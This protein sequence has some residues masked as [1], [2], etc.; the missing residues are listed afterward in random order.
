ME[1]SIEIEVRSTE[2]DE[3][4][5]VNN[6]KY[7]EYLEWGREHWYDLTGFGADRLSEKNIGT[8]VVN[9]NINYR[10]EAR[11]GEHLNIVTRPVRKGNTSF[12]LKQEIYNR[13]KQRVADAEVTIVIF[14]LI[15]RCSTPIP[16]SLVH[17]FT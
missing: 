10:R 14:D 5:H 16:A 12:V 17:V 6:A 1:S 4:G 13:E 8:V 9:L 2:I 7:L 3:V 11:K 15:K